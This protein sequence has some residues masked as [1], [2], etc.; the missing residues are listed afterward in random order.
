MQRAGATLCRGKRASPCGSFSCCGAWA[1]ECTAFSDLW[2]MGF[3][4]HGLQ[5]SVAQGLS[6]C[7]Q[8]QLLGGMWSLLRPGIEPIPCIGRQIV[9]HCTTR[10]VQNQQ[11]WVIIL[12]KVFISY[13]SLLLFFSILHIRQTQDSHSDIFDSESSWPLVWFKYGHIEWF[14]GQRYFKIFKTEHWPIHVDV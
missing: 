12:E 2:G 7:I 6:N 5:W 4:V 3:R 8:P 13:C 1:L 9:I 14:F 10:E 11:F